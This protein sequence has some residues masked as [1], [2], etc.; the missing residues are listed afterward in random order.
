M[1]EALYFPNL[2]LPHSN[3]VNPAILY[4]D[5]I[6]V[7]APMGSW[8]GLYDRRTEELIGEDLVAPVTPGMNGWNRE[9]DDRFVRY[10]TQLPAA[11]KRDSAPASV[12]LGKLAYTSLVDDLR[13]T[14]LLQDDGDGW[15][16]APRWAADQVLTYL[17]LQMTTSS[18]MEASLVTDTGPAWT[19]VTGVAASERRRTRELQAV[20]SLLPVAA[21][22]ST[23][24]LVRFRRRHK[25]ALLEFRHEIARALSTPDNH[26]DL[27]ELQL[28]RDE[29]IADLRGFNIA[30]SSVSVTVTALPIGAALMEGSPWS[31]GAG[32][33][34]LAMSAWGEAQRGRRAYTAHRDPMVYAAIARMKLGN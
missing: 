1:V 7:I 18:H 8:D 25:R 5:R 12:H 29:L 17:A 19:R 32:M 26:L 34:A 13:A 33:A 3:W 10:L 9:A 23:T 11:Q 16:A 30:S 24:E 31:A 2:S 15:L 20:T 22:A 28:R 14:G 27:W 6:Q 21:S 4:F